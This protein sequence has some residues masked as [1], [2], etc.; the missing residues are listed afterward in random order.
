MTTKRGDEDRYVI[1]YL[2]EYVIYVV[3]RCV[4]ESMIEEGAKPAVVITFL[5][6][7]TDI[8]LN[9]EQY[10]RAFRRGHPICWLIVQ[11]GGIRIRTGIARKTGVLDQLGLRSCRG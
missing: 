9:H 4:I 10:D 6:A 7:C 11:L 5:Y 1:C 8:L 3:Q 2:G